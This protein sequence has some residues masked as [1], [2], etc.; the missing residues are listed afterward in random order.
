MSKFKICP[1]CGC[2]N[3]PSRIECSQCEADL[4]AVPVSDEN[5]AQERH[6]PAKA[7]KMIRLCS[8]GEKNPPSARKCT[9]C[10]EDISDIIPSEDS[11][12]AVRQMILAS[13]DGGYAFE[14]TAPETTVGRECAMSEYLSGK[15]FVSR[16]HARLDIDGG[17]LLITNLSDTNRTYLN[18]IL[19]T[20]TQE[21]HDGDEIGL[22]GCVI[23]GSRQD[24]A[25]YFTVRICCT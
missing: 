22:G 5:K 15:P 3:P 6:E 2:H 14:V 10:G 11:G 9:A 18:D 16:V 7:V 20:G 24:G 1:D 23:D 19:I 25:A 4:T 17:R 21:L 13:V 8:C 12:N